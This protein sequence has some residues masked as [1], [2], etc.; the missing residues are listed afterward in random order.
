MSRRP[1]WQ[2]N[3]ER[4]LANPR[5]VRI[6]YAATEAARR[7][8]RRILGRLRGLAGR[9]HIWGTS[10]KEGPCEKSE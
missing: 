3:E 4:L 8:A 5:A 2:E 10:P 1:E 6:V 9:R 7:Q